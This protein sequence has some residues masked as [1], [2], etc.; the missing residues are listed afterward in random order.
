MHKILTIIALAFI[1]ATATAQTVTERMVAAFDAETL[2]LVPD[3][4][5]KFYFEKTTLVRRKEGSKGLLAL[6]Q[7][8]NG[9]TLDE[10][11]DTGAP[12]GISYNNG[13]ILP[14]KVAPSVAAV[15]STPESKPTTSVE[16][17][18][19]FDRKKD[20][21]S[22][23]EKV[24]KLDGSIEL[25]SQR[26]TQVVLDV[27]ESNVISAAIF[28]ISVIVFSAVMWAIVC[29]NEAI[30]TF[31]R[32]LFRSKFDRSLEW[33]RFISAFAMYCMACTL[34]IAGLIAVRYH[35]DWTFV[36]R[37]LISPKNA[38]FVYGIVAV[39]LYAWIITISTPNSADDDE[40][41]NQQTFGLHNPRGLHRGGQ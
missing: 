10:Q 6:L 41:G 40:V 34:L 4:E 37:L 33:A 2:A 39:K 1:T 30:N 24:R 22:F 29:R 12:R 13:L 20:T 3:G 8:S 21:V 18:S 35:D 36:F 23:K 32:S 28:W 19:L 26:G 7:N 38:F 16:P 25:A 27:M 15:A 9:M 14:Q 17:V 5:V 31:A 11:M